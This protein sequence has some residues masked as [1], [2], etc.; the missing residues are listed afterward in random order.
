MLANIIRN[1][2]KTATSDPY[3]SSVSL[4]LHMD[5]ANNSTSFVDSGPN[6]ATVTV[7]G[8]AQISTAQSKFGGAS[9]YFYTNSAVNGLGNYIKINNPNTVFGSIS[10]DFTI[11]TW[12]YFTTAPPGNGSG[13][14][15]QLIGQSTWP[16][17]NPG[18]WWGFY[19]VSTGLYFYA[20]GGGSFILTQSATFTWSTGRWYHVAAVRQNGNLRLYLDGVQTGTTTSVTKTIFADNVRPLAI[21]ADSTG[22][23]QAMDGYL[24]DIRITKYART[25]TVPTA[26]YPNA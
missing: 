2:R 11:E 4:L 1:A 16:E 20:A 13:Y 18:N 12:V 25:I 15:N 21:A 7:N 14:E 8:N 26:P 10:G 9:G 22:G 24:D 5:G 6:A 23:K 17:S 19:A 3:F